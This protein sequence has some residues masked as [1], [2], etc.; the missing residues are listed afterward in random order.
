MESESQPEAVSAAAEVVLAN[1]PTGVGVATL[2]DPDGILRGM[3]I[4][5]LTKVSDEPPGVLACIGGAASMRPF[6]TVGQLI[7]ITLLAAGQAA[8]SAGF[9]YASAEPFEDF[10]WSDVDYGIPILRQN[11]GSL[12]G[13]V[14]RVVEHCG[15]GVVLMN[16]VDA[17]PYERHPLIYWRK[18]YW[19]RLD[20]DSDQTSGRW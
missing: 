19:D 1:V 15:T 8:K 13:R 14:D 7:G 17:K 10:A 11:A 12:L 18:A 16:V 4:S 2:V 5:S 20:H 9:A 6:I 3:T